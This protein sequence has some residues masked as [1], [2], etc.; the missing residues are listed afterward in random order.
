MPKSKTIYDCLLTPQAVTDYNTKYD[1]EL[2]YE[3][4]RW[5]LHQDLDFAVESFC[6][7]VEELKEKFYLEQHKHT[8]SSEYLNLPSELI[9]NGAFVQAVLSRV[10]LVVVPQTWNTPITK[11][12]WK[13]SD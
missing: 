3:E 6:E 11:A 4:C 7:Q 8:S 10:P 1:E 12:E 2:S 9:D 5:Q 13:G